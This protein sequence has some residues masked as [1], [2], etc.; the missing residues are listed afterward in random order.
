MGELA[1]IIQAVKENK[2]NFYLIM[3]KMS[4]LI[5]K[6]V[7]MLYKDEE[8]DVRSELMTAL[9]EAVTD[10]QYYE[11]DGQIVSFINTAI[12]NRYLE[13]YKKS[14]KIHD[15]ETL[16]KDEEVVFQ[17]IAYQGNEYDDVL[18]KEDA[19]RIIN[20]Y[21]GLKKKIVYCFF[22][23]ELSDSEIAEQLNVSRQYV[24]RIRRDLRKKVGTLE[25]DV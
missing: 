3:D 16:T 1:E 10:L 19:L 14:R 2:N 12:R 9:W 7:R 8:E 4:P 13:L 20:T 5:N 24:N 22:V 25:Y 6:Y 18:F 21:S 17:T 11:N 15:Y 23:K